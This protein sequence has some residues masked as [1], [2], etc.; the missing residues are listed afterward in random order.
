MSAKND[1]PNAKTVFEDLRKRFEAQGKKAEEE[2]SV[3]Q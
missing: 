2:N 1:V 3:A